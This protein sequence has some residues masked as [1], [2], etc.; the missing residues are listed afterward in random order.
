M[1][2]LGNK[3]H[4]LIR[5]DTALS[6]LSLLLNAEHLRRRLSRLI[7][8][9]K[10]SDFRLTYLR[11]KPGMNCLGRYEFQLAGKTQLA[12]AKAFGADAAIKLDKARM[13]PQCHGPLGP[14]RLVVQ[15]SNL[16]ISF[17][18]NDLRLKSIA[19]LA[20]P[21]ARRRLL[22]RIFDDSFEW[23]GCEESI[24][25]Y[26]PERRLVVHLAHP[27]GP[28]ATLKLYTQRE[29]SRIS[30]LGK[31]E[32][33]RSELRLPRQIGH[34]KKHCAFAFDW[35][36]GDTLRSYRQDSATVETHFR[37]AGQLIARYHTSS[38]AGLGPAD[39]PQQ[40]Q[41]LGSLAGQL[42]FMLPELQDTATKLAEG[43][44][45]VPTATA[46]DLRPVHGDFYDKQVIVGSDGL[47]LIDLD[48]THL[49]NIHEDLGCFLAHQ[50]RLAITNPGAGAEQNSSLSNAF[51][52]GYVEAGGQFDEQQL[53]GWTALH[54]FRLSH[55]PFRDRA[56]DWPN[57]THSILRRAGELIRASQQRLHL[58]AG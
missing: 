32:L 41:I 49:G 10:L 27:K 57:Q 6:G 40:V 58:A 44:Q 21:V 13:L 30:Q 46:V 1:S 36:T 38:V 9:S 47:S 29:F 26:K 37:R 34:S 17:F 15:E 54:L 7:D 45:L 4:D 43:L 48:R 3:D 50:E 53:A 11:Y 39:E 5:R 18:P 55:H 22:G 8:T 14:G 42:T 35:I 23:D 25:N 28:A 24:L 31:P 19:R 12:Y 16:F 56:K 33:D 20:E 52:D 2:T 51:L